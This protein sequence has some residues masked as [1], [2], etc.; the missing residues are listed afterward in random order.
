MIYGTEL[1][2]DG[3]T[4][5]VIASAGEYDYSWHEAALLRLDGQLYFAESSGCSCY[6]FEDNVSASDLEPVRN[7]QEAVEKAKDCIADE[8]VATFA[9]RLAEI[10]PASSS[11]PGVTL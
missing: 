4:Y 3:N 8:H 2:I 6:G 10:R 9:E 11:V 1:K 5:E 7:W